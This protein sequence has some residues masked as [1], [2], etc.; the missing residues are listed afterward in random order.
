[1]NVS[2]RFCIA[3]L[4]AAASLSA[5]AQQQA[6][7]PSQTLACLTPAEA[8][9]GAPTYPEKSFERKESG[10][11][12]VALDFNAADREPK[13]TVT[14]GDDRRDL[15]R[16]VLDHVRKYRVPCLAPGQT[17][18]LLQDFDFVPT[19]GRKV[20][21]LAP[22][23]ADDVRRSRLAD[24]VLHK[25]PGTKPDY[26]WRALRNETQGTVVLRLSFSAP[27]AAPAIEVFNDAQS[28]DLATAASEFARD[29]RMP[30]HEG[31]PVGVTQFYQFRIEGGARTVLKD[32]S[33]RTLLGVIK[34][35]RQANVYFD[36]GEMGCPFDLR[37]ILH[38][39]Y[40]PNDVGEVGEPRP[41]RRFFLDWLRRQQLD[42]PAPAHNA[43]LGDITTVSVPCTV[44]NLGTI[45]GGSASQ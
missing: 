32:M 5:A 6:L 45:S 12:S 36:F 13:V 43:V 23:D 15:L 31:A 17:A 42:L 40:G 9:R 25:K 33:I 10:R 14:Y 3:A 34:D 22:I 18:R 2:L 19:D 29:F 8:A 7:T 11:V 16:A 37:F 24:C 4:A 35:I 30:C 41:E 28:G 26:P 38:Q 21:W 20:R 44:L 1:V 27:D 39:P